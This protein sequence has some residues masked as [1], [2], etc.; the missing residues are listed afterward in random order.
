MGLHQVTM[1][2]LT[3]KIQM[4]QH[5]N[6]ADVVCSLLYAYSSG[7]SWRDDCNLVRDL[8]TSHHILM[9]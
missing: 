6:N 5:V 2:L 1:P 7:L 8:A 3:C 4:T 9:S